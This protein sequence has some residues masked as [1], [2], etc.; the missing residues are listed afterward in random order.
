MFC[1]QNNALTD[2]HDGTLSEIPYALTKVGVPDHLTV[3]CVWERRGRVRLCGVSP[4]HGWVMGVPQ[5]HSRQLAVIRHCVCVFRF[6]SFTIR[7]CFGVLY[8][9]HITRNWKHVLVKSKAVAVWFVILCELWKCSMEKFQYGFVCVFSYNCLPLQ[10]SNF[11]AGTKDP[12]LKTLQ[13]FKL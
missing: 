9:F 6:I 11:L 4:F 2:L 7:I 8:C 3:K 12:Q 10:S 13:K 1:I 5:L